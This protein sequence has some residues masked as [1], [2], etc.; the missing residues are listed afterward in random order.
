[1][2]KLKEILEL[3]PPLMP[4]GVGEERFVSTGHRCPHCKG[5]GVF[6]GLDASGVYDEEVPCGVCHGSGVV[7]ATVT[8][9][10]RG[11]HVSK[12]VCDE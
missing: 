6:W 5:R 2:S 9:S 12:E 11:S 7:E 1:M 8:V 4:C 3:R 10:W